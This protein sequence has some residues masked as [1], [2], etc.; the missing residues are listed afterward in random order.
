MNNYYINVGP[1]LAKEHKIKW[2]KSRCRIE[3]NSIFSFSLVSE[4]EVRN[5]V[6]EIKIIKSSA[7]EG[8][9]SR[10]LK[11]S[12]EVII[13]EL[14]FLYN[15]SLQHGI[16][17]EI[18]GIGRVTP[19]PKTKHRSTKPSDWR[20]ISQISLPGKL[21]E[22][23]IH[24]QLSH[25]LNIHNLLSDKQYGFRKGLST[26]FAIFDVLKELYNNLNESEYSGCV[27]IDFSKAFD[28][29]DHYILFQK[30]KLY[31]LD[32]NSLN[33]FES[34]MQNRSQRTIINTH[35]STVSPITYGTVQGS[36]LG[37]LIFILYVNDMFDSVN[38]SGNIYMYA[39][40]TLIVTQ[41]NNIEDVSNQITVGLGKVSTWCEANKL[42]MNYKKTKCMVIKHKK[43]QDVPTVCVKN[44]QIGIV[45]SYEY[46]GIL[47]DEHLTH[48]AYVEN[49]WKK[50]NTKIGILSKIRRFI[51]V[52][53]AVQI[54]KC[55]IRP[56]LDYID[57]VIDSSS[58]ENISKLDRLQNKAIRRIEYCVNADHRK[59]ID[60][61]HR[62]YNI[63]KLPLRRKRNLVKIIYRESKDIQNINHDRPSIE[64]RSTTKVKMKQKFTSL[65]KIQSS[66]LY[67]GIK[68]WDTLPTNLQKEKD[69]IT[70]KAEIMKLE[71]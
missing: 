45:H 66:P 33:F 38:Q 67:R 16:F 18:W 12:F 58:K 2:E 35:A 52:K 43:N 57:Y 6:K 11:D 60:L 5:L 23:I 39:D 48:N 32:P 71:L 40:D 31:G 9:S 15:V 42:S 34:Y 7:I 8:L 30:L 14:T 46:L 44:K 55:M 4:N 27:F 36:I 3:T 28:T 10:L 59:D 26:T 13:P 37:P 56:H 19:I 62:E 53:T 64:L 63:E 69:F 1:T 51:T 21:L 61:L 29:I 24:K 25:Y 22:K 49:V 50:V 20:P 47:I 54:Y 68:L 41:S 17:P 65:T 70:F